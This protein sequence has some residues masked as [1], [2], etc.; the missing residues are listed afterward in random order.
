MGKEA[1]NKTTTIEGV[2]KN[3]KNYAVFNL[4]FL[5]LLIVSASSTFVLLTVFQ[6]MKQSDHMH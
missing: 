1:K 6:L 4:L 2:T 5:V 3:I